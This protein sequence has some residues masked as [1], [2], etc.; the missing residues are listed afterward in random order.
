M[1][2]KEKFLN[3][4]DLSVSNVLVNF[5]NKELLPGTNITKSRFWVGL[6]KTLHELSPKNKKLLE[7]REKY[8]NP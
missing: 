8:K 2:K 3:I 5:I 4:F 7:T 6:S 1:K